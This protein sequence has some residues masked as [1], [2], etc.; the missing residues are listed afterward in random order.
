MGKLYRMVVPERHGSQRNRPSALLTMDCLAW[1]IADI[2]KPR[3]WIQL[4]VVFP[5][6]L[7]LVP[8]RYRRY[9][10]D[11]STSQELQNVQG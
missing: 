6:A 11:Y 9:L 1:R 2:S 5:R 4:Y 8:P 7:Y 3:L 10:D